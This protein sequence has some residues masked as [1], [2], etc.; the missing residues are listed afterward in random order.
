VIRVITRILA[1]TA[2]I[3]HN[4]K[5]GQPTARSLTAAIWHNDKTGQPTARSLTAYDH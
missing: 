1:L 3:W 5:T 4:D 2:A